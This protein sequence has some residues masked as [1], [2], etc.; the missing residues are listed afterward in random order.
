MR[1]DPDAKVMDDWNDADYFSDTSCVNNEKLKVL[2]QSVPLFY[3]RFVTGEIPPKP[4]T[5]S[6]DFGSA[7]HLALLEPEKWDDSVAVAPNAKKTTKAGKAEWSEFLSGNEGKLILTE[8]QIEVV[9]KMKESVLGNPASEKLINGGGAIERPITFTDPDTG[10]RCKIKPDIL[11]PDGTIV[12]FKYSADP[13]EEGFTRSCDRFSY[14]CS[15]ALYLDGVRYLRG[16][17]VPHV[18]LVCGNEPPYECFVYSLDEESIQ[19]GRSMNLQA[20]RRLRDCIDLNDWTSR[21][22][23][24]VNT[25]SM[26]RWSFNRQL[27]Y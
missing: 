9:G 27:V 12:D 18:F 14:H 3:G 1:H 19:L 5:K 4:S 22:H 26:P 20:L 21:M 24:K 23:G 8:E 16:Y 11:L 6:L 25:L 7:F 13:Y 15:A 17:E 10:I 2:R